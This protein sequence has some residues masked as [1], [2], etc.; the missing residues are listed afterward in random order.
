MDNSSDSRRSFIKK[1]AIGA[2]GLNGRG[3]AHINAGIATANAQVTGICDVD[4][5]VLAKVSKLT[6]EWKGGSPKVFT[7]FRNILTNTD[8][9]AV[10][11]AAPDHWHTPMAMM[12]MKAGKHVYLEKPCNLT[13]QEGE[14]LIQSQKKYGKV[15]QIGNQQR[16]AP[17]SIMAIK[18][19]Q[20]GIIGEG[21]MCLKDLIGISG[22]A[23][24]RGKII[25]TIS[26]TIT[27]TGSG[28]GEVEK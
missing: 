6:K 16:S 8:V 5:Q 1:S 2:I 12:A 25:R 23:P 13:P 7:D 18:D 28:I 19:I 26:Y 11:I 10:T 14:W 3:Q 24:L 21:R 17:T 27:G 22:K 4:A 20:D 9:D 15:L